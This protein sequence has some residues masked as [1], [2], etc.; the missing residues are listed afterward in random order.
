[1]RNRVLRSHLHQ[2]NRHTC[3]INHRR[4]PSC[5]LKDT[6]TRRSN[7]PRQIIRASTIRSLTSVNQT[8]INR[9]TTSRQAKRR[10]WPPQPR[11]GSRATATRCPR[12]RWLDHHGWGASPSK[13]NGHHGH[14]RK[15]QIPWDPC[16]R[17]SRR[18]T[19]CPKVTWDTL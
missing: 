10:P 3:S 8:C 1:M 9:T 6:H 2:A 19:G 4:P 15:C 7:H 14:H 16:L 12:P 18:T 17:R 13:T 11:P 5:P